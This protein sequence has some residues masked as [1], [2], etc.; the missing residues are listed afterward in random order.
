MLEVGADRQTG[1]QAAD[2]HLRGA[3]AQLADAMAALLDDPARAQRLADEARA[4][5]ATVQSDASVRRFWDRLEACYREA[6][7]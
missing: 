1:G 2:P 3:V 6:V 5:V 4:H 7:G